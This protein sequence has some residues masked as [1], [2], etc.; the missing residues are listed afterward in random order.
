MFLPLQSVFCFDLY[1]YRCV[2][3]CP[4]MQQ[5]KLFWGFRVHFFS[6]SAVELLKVFNSMVLPSN[7]WTD[8]WYLWGLD[9]SLN[10][11]PPSPIHLWHQYWKALL[12]WSNRCSMGFRFGEFAAHTILMI[13]SGT[14]TVFAS[15]SDVDRHHHPSRWILGHEQLCREE[16]DSIESSVHSGV[17]GQQT[18]G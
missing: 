13:P 9:F 2:I 12:K 11:S 5:D 8:F 18:W 7:S 1:W 17:A 16:C 4:K 3:N 15:W 6:N 10:V 14:K